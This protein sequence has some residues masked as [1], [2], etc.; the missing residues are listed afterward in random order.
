MFK[1]TLDDKGLA[2]K[3]ED[4]NFLTDEIEWLG[5]KIDSKKTTHLIYKS[6][7]IQNLKEAKGIKDIRS[8]MGLIDQLNKHTP[9]LTSLSTPFR[10]SKRKKN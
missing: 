8:V 2:K 10:E 6:D 3:R 7:A 4:C 5:F 9:N 1:K